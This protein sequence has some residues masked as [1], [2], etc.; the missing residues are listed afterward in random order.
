MNYTNKINPAIYTWNTGGQY[1]VTCD[2]TGSSNTFFKAT[3]GDLTELTYSD[4]T[5]KFYKYNEYISIGTQ[6]Y[7]AGYYQKYETVPFT[8]IT[9]QAAVPCSSSSY[10][11]GSQGNISLYFNKPFIG[12]LKI[13]TITVSE[14]YGSRTSGSYPSTPLAKVT[15]SGEITVPQTCKINDGQIIDIDYGKIISS[16]IKTKGAGADGFSGIVT[17]V[18]YVCKNMKDGVKIVFIFNGQAASGDSDSL[19]TDNDDIGIRIENLQGQT[20]TPNS[21][22][23][24]TQFDFSSQSGS[25]S[26]KTYPVNI[27]GNVPEAGRFSSTATI[28]SNFE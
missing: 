7:L 6:I 20:V 9:T 13:P 17:Q 21:G 10:G 28:T 4:S 23:L 11:T 1:Y 26:F 16:N 5:Y 15:I 22:K 25:A 2:C 14:L 27:S 3:T 8:N 19:A 24:L 12:S 18:A